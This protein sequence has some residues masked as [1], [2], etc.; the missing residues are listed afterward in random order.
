MGIRLVK[1]RV[2]NS[3]DRADSPSA[4]IISESLARRYWPGEDP[5]GKHLTLGYNHTGPREIVGIVGDVKNVQLAENTHPALYTAFEQAPW[6]FLAVVAR[7]SGAESALLGSLRTAIV[8]VDPDQPVGRMQTVTEYVARSIATPR[9]T[10][11]LVG[12]F[13]TTALLLA[14]F[15]LFSVMAYSVAQRRREIGIRVALGAQAGNLRWMVVGQ[16]LRLGSVGLGLGLIGAFAAARVLDSL[17]FGVSANDPFTFTGVCAMLLVVLM[18][19]AYLPARRA[20]RVD[21]IVALR[22]E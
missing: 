1:G 17:L 19:A 8:N 21:P 9:F 2:F 14:G 13:A 20:T 4:V 12:S 10:A 11:T 7:T 22:A 16:A 3:G 6:P 15:G 18:A 5:I